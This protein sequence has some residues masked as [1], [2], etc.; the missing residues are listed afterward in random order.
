MAVTATCFAF[1][2][3]CGAQ[4]LQTEAPRVAVTDLLPESAVSGPLFSLPPI[5]PIQNYLG[6]FELR[7][8]YG[9]FNVSGRRM[10]A[11]RE[12]ELPAIQALDQVNKTDAFQQSLTQAASA[13]VQLVRSAVTNPAGTVENLASGLGTIFGRIGRVAEV[14]VNAVVDKATDLSS[15]AQPSTA[16]PSAGGPAPPLFTGD[17]FGY[18]KARRE[19]AKKLNID[20]YTTNPV[21]RPKLDQAAAASFA[22]SFAIDTALGLAAAPL[23]YAVEFDDTVRDSVWNV[24]AIDLQSRNQATLTAMG[25]DGRVVRDFFRNRWFTPTLQTALVTALEQFP[26]A[27]GRESVIR[28]ATTVE[29]EVRARALVNGVRA[30]AVHQS[31]TGRFKS[32]TA[33]GVLV[34]GVALSGERVVAAD[35]DY[36]W[37]NAQAAEFARR[38][39]IT[40]RRKL[41]LVTG[42]V[43]EDARRGLERAGWRV[44]ADAPI[45]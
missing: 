6:Q 7:S 39:G 22:G 8:T 18:N 9:V 3:S 45:K 36:V 33:S 10:L 35:L 31:S 15:G 20:P 32:I 40:E 17:P 38:P 24:P 26:G 14:G 34:A 28:D 13:P 30:L 1:S 5:V 42:R 21:L 25:I 4:P 2:L 23:Q 12:A 41:V 19:W 29:G 44:V 16:A 11:V 37:W 27:T 43:D